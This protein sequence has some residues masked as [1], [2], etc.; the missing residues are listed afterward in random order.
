MNQIDLMDQKQEE[1]KKF[2]HTA[3]FQGL[4]VENAARIMVETAMGNLL[5]NGSDLDEA[6]KWVEEVVADF[7]RIQSWQS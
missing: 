4:E 7:K 3:E 1:L 2:I 6:G 5:R